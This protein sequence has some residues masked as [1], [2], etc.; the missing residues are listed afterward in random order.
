MGI[1]VSNLPPVN[2][3]S[4]ILNIVSG[5]ETVRETELYQEALYWR[6]EG[7]SVFPLGFDKKPLVAWSEYQ[8]RRPYEWEIHNWFKRLKGKIGGIAVVLGSVSVRMRSSA[9]AVRDFDTMDAYRAWATANRELAASLPTARTSRGVHVF[10]RVAGEKPIV[11]LYDAKG[12]KTGDFRCDKGHYVALAPSLH[13]SGKRYEWVNRPATAADIPLVLPSKTGFL[14]DGGTPQRESNPATRMPAS[15]PPLVNTATLNELPPAVAR[16]VRESLPT[17]QGERNARIFDLAR[18]LK[19]I[20]PSRVADGWAEAVSAW[21][22]VALPVIGTKAWSV[23]WKDF[24]TAYGNVNATD[25]GKSRLMTRIRD[26]ASSPTLTTARERLLAAFTAAF[27]ETNGVSFF[28]AS[29]TAADLAGVKQT[30]ACKQLANLIRDGFVVVAE[31]GKPSKTCRRG[32]TRYAPGPK[33]AVTHPRTPLP[34][35]TPP[36]ANPS[37]DTSDVSDPPPVS[38]TVGEMDSCT[39]VGPSQAVSAAPTVR[40]IDARQLGTWPKPD[41]LSPAAIVKAVER[42]GGTIVLDGITVVVSGPA[43]RLDELAEMVLARGI[44]VAQHLRQ[45]KPLTAWEGGAA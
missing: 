35:S 29:R 21:F 8:T 32:T 39:N 26:A 6:G 19:G 34:A 28:L 14:T 33:L 20:D 22:A 12:G 41:A 24:V 37:L 25:A 30:T 2:Q 18:K 23:S 3:D 15:A 7:W 1:I 5:V 31:K 45:R 17:G 4:Q 16:A 38:P 11:T 9:L 10:C 44:A 42:V 36:D 43:E 13:P 27:A 40:R